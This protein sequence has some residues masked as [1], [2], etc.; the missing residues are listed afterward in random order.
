MFSAGIEQCPEWLMFRQ[1]AH[2][3]GYLS[4][5]EIDSACNTLF[6]E[7]SSSDVFPLSIY[8]NPSRDKVTVDGVGDLRI[9]VYD[10]QGRCIFRSDMKNEKS[11]IDVSSWEPGLYTIGILS[12]R[13]SSFS[14]LLVYE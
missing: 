2:R 11:E 13:K 6:V 10:L 14:K 4:Q 5:Q 12:G 7:P 9:S 3:S 8:P 1:D